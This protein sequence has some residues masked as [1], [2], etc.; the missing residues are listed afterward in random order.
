MTTSASW[1]RTLVAGVDDAAHDARVFEAAATLAER[2]DAQLFLLHVL[3]F[4]PEIP[5][6]AHV[7]PDRLETTVA[8]AAR[9]SL[10]ALM[11]TAPAVR[12]GPPIVVEG[13]PWRRILDVARE[14]AADLIVV[15]GHRRHGLERVLGT[16]A[17]KV[18]NHASRHVL[19]VREASEARLD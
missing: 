8:R 5:P 9:A 17:S 11:A 10:H 4:P 2:L 14:L 19:V 1:A 6:A 16:V 3:A 15:G 12:F 13:E 18:V 7:A